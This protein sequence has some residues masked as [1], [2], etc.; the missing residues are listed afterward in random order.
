MMRVNASPKPHMPAAITNAVGEVRP[1]SWVSVA[2]HPN[3]HPHRA[4]RPRSKATVP[5]ALQN[6]SRSN[7]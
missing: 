3:C 1:A 7:K 5:A 2:R 4:A 6:K